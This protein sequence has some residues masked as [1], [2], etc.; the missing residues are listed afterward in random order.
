[1]NT[2]STTSAITFID[3]EKGILRYRGYPIEQLGREVDLRRDELPAHLRQAAEQAE[4]ELLHQAHAPLADPRGHEAL[5]RRLPVD[6]APDGD[7]GV[8]GV[9]SLSSFYPET[10]DVGNVPEQVDST[11][12]ALLAKVRTIAAYSLQEVDRPALRLPD[13]TRWATARTS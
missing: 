3:G 10:L 5:L 12:H 7:P 13:R 11:T 8:D 2:A 6:G 9:N 4:L 1:M